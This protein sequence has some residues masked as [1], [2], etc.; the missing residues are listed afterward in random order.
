MCDSLDF[1]ASGTGERLYD[2]RSHSYSARHRHHRD[3]RPPRTGT[4]SVVAISTLGKA[5]VRGKDYA[6]VALPP[7]DKGLV[8]QL[9]SPSR[10]RFDPR[11]YALQH[12]GPV[13]S[14]PTGTCMHNKTRKGGTNHAS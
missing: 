10:L 13:C 12:G 4:K 8:N 5:V 2:G 14:R 1:V 3:N 7:G 9:L 11:T 6:G